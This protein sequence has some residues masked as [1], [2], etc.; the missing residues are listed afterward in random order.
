MLQNTL[1]VGCNLFDAK[2]R[3][4]RRTRIETDS[5]ALFSHGSR[6]LINARAA[7]RGVLAA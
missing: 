2:A 5:L 6:V 3:R 1:Q 7:L 4:L